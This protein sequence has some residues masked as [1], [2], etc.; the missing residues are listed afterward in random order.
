MTG[1]STVDVV[2]GVSV[3]EVVVVVVVVV[4]VGCD[5]GGLVGFVGFGGLVVVDI[6]VVEA[7]K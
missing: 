7:F 6:S 4:V 3:V 1:S 5:P 2:V